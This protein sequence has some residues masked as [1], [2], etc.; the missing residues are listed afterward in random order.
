MGAGAG[1][2][3]ADRLPVR[4][5]IRGVAMDTLTI[6][7]AAGQEGGDFMR[8]EENILFILLG[9]LI[10]VSIAGWVSWF[11]GVT[12]LATACFSGVLVAEMFWYVFGCGD[13]E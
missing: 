7:L 4:G 13:I 11:A 9:L 8:T 5:S 6:L 10:L 2:R 3:R 12:W 1:S